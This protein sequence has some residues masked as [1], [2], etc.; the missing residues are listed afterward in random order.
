MYLFL[1]TF[2]LTTMASTSEKTFGS[3]LENAKT[4][5]THLHSFKDYAALEPEQTAD[6]LDTVI[7]GIVA[8]NKQLA[9]N[10]SLYSGA[11]ET[12]QQLYQKA[13][14]SVIKLMSPVAKAISSFYGKESKELADVSRLVSKIRGDK[15]TKA[16]KKGTIPEEDEVSQSAKSYGSMKQNFAD[17]IAKLGKLTKYKPA[18]QKITIAALTAKLQLLQQGND[19]VAVT[20]GSLKKDKD[21]RTANYAALSA[22]VLRIK[23][24]VSSQYTNSSSE[25]KL[26]KGLSV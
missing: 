5:C 12:R 20:Y 11:V 25:Y 15:P 24:A 16:G 26:I 3:K 1:I 6:N 18:N 17:L 4:I 7:A 9:E 22:L 2:K 8:D 23:D 10:L 14:D 19:D 13:P 21:K